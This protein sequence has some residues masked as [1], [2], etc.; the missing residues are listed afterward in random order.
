MVIRCSP[1]LC[2]HLINLGTFCRKLMEQYHPFAFTNVFWFSFYCEAHLWHVSYH[3]SMTPG[4]YGI[5]CARGILF[6]KVQKV[7]ER[8]VFMTFLCENKSSCDCSSLI[9]EI[10]IR[11]N[12]LLS[13]SYPRRSLKNFLCFCGAFLCL[14]PIV[15]GCQGLL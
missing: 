14:G 2:Q 6:Y 5:C 1:F 3:L 13:D 8:I 4:H 12:F 9:W 15:L 11:K 10:F 7:H